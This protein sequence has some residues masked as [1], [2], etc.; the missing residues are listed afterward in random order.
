MSDFRTSPFFYC[1]TDGIRIT[2]RALY[3]EDK[4]NPA[5]SRYVFAYHVRIEN[6]GPQAAQLLSRHWIIRDS[7]G[8]DTEVSGDGVIGEQP[9]LERSGVHEYESF[10]VLKSSSGTMEGTYRFLREDGSHFD[11]V[12][13]RFYLEAG[14]TI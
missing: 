3:L 12:I 9:R 6:V 13:P 14:E 1:E 10:C 2:V 5:L 8:E 11:A 4:S 7:I